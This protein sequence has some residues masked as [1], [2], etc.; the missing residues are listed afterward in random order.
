VSWFL[1]REVVCKGEVA[2]RNLDR[3]PALLVVG[4]FRWSGVEWSCLQLEVFS[5]SSFSR[6]LFCCSHDMYPS[7]WRVAEQ[8]FEEI[9]SSY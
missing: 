9:P 2:E 7:R 8:V 4:R 6:F 3:D 5:I 1:L